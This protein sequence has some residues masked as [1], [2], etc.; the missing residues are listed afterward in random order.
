LI[1][2]IRVAKILRTDGTPDECRCLAIGEDG[3]VLARLPDESSLSFP[4]SEIRFL[5]ESSCSLMPLLADS[6]IHLG[7]SDGVA[8]SYKFHT[9][10]VVEHQLAKYLASGIGHVLSLGT[11]QP[12]IQDLSKD[13][14][15]GRASR[16]AFPYS[17]GC[18][19]GAT[20]GW[21]PELTMPQLRYRPTD[22]GS[23]RQ[24]VRDLNNGGVSTLKLW[25]DDLGGTV[26][27]MPIAISEAIIDEAHRHSLKV[28][29]HVFTESDACEL[30]TA[31]IDALAHSVRDHYLDFTFAENMANKGVRLMP[32]L[33]REEAALAFASENNPYLSD[34]FFRRSA[35]EL[36]DEVA[37]QRIT[38]SAKEVDKAKRSLDVAASN[39]ATLS[40]VGVE[41]CLGTDA[42]FLLKLPGFSQ[43]RELQ[44]MVL[45]G[46]TETQALAAAMKNN[47][48]FFATGASDL[49][50]G[51]PADFVLLKGDPLA[52]IRNTTAIQQVW[53]NGAPVREADAA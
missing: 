52:D 39:L 38:L 42:G 28:C 8:E 40:K 46:L 1:T 25:V 24:A 6:H 35:G 51:R 41:I 29:S 44:L 33:V 14:L 4:N 21:P 5:N 53:R 37:V 32:T 7:I 27:K 23:A 49:S 18:G 12:W 11:D 15:N 20:A 36:L 48:Q 19:F 50:I 13:Y 34:P 45:A 26:P 43:H 30:I 31:G 10:E 22:P 9:P 2:V 16:G 17:A 3:N 47:Y